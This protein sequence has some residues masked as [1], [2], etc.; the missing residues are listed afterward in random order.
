MLHIVL[1]N[2]EIPQNTGSIGR[3]CV[4]TDTAL[5]LVHPLGFDAS[6]ARVRRAGLDYWEHLAP[7]HY[8]DWEDFLARNPARRLWYFT[9]KGSRRH[10][11]VDWKDGDGLVFG[12]ETRGLQPEILEANPDSQLCI[13]MPGEFH[14]SLNL[15]Q[16][17]AVGLYE[18]MRQI[19][20]W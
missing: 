17:A 11:D 4:S 1:V 20:G 16:A 9:T 15:A 7:T 13:P 14:R 10:T 3:L 18:A 2:P 6:A 5:H 12:R 8:Q 19:Q